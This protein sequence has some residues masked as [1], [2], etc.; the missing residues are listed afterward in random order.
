MLANESVILSQTNSLSSHRWMQN[1]DIL[2]IDSYHNVCHHPP[3]TLL[4]RHVTLQTTSFKIPEQA[5]ILGRCPFKT[6]PLCSTQVLPRS[7]NTSTRRSDVRPDPLPVHLRR[8][9]R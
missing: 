9:F 5:N 4:D 7:N 1:N 2:Q 3:H 6:M 8:P